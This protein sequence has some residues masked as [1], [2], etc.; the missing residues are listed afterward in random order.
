MRIVRSEGAGFDSRRTR[1]RRRFAVAVGTVGRIGRVIDKAVAVVRA[2]R[3]DTGR[4]VLARTS[5]AA[6]RLRIIGT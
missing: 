4:R 2:G 3:A 5:G 6:R 1:A